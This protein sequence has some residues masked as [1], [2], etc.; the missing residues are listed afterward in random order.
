[1]SGSGGGGGGTGNT[2]TISFTATASQND[3]TAGDVPALA[4]V[5][6]LTL[7]S[8]SVNDGLVTTLTT[9]DGTTLSV[10]AGFVF[11]GGE[12]VVATFIQ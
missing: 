7:A 4:S 6:A 2:T 1:M 3:Y 5:A 12:P 10:D 9:W 8:I 11:Y